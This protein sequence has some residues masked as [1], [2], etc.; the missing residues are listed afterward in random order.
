MSWP[1]ATDT[2]A[3]MFL[4]AEQISFASRI[5][6]KSHP[7]LEQVSEWSAKREQ[8]KL[9]LHDI[10]ILL[11][12]YAQRRKTRYPANHLITLADPFPTIRLS[13]ACDSL[14]QSV[15]SM[16]DIAAGIANK[17]SQGSCGQAS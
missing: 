1:Q 17:A 2:I 12:A 10:P 7:Y 5:C 14:A 15:Y 6:H 3:G 4:S 11:T 9:Y 8:L 13:S 16:A